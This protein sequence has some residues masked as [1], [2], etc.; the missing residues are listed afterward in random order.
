MVTTKIKSNRS[1]DKLKVITGHLFVHVGWAL[2][3]IYS[4]SLISICNHAL[5]LMGVD[6]RDSHIYL[7]VY[8][9]AIY[10]L[11][12]PLLYIV[13]VELRVMRIFTKSIILSW[14][15]RSELFFFYA[16]GI[17]LFFM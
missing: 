14:F 15:V 11:L 10:I 8:V 12:F 5:L 13:Y 17:V 7:G 4:G 1:E 6:Y 3:I 9:Y 16:I 2:S